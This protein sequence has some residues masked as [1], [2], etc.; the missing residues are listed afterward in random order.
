MDFLVESL[1][2]SVDSD[3]AHQSTPYLFCKNQPLSRYDLFGLEDTEC[4]PGKDNAKDQL[5][6]LIDELNKLTPNPKIQA[7]IALLNAALSGKKTCKDMTQ[8]GSDCA[9]F[10]KD[11]VVEKCMKCCQDLAASMP[12]GGAFFCTGKCGGSFPD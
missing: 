10:A 3:V 9:D 1:R 7:L 11:M 2:F 4:C 12:D 6:N 8:A 5:K